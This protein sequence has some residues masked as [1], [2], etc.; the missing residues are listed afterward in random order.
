VAEA[1]SIG[2]RLPLGN[3]KG[4][5]W[6]AVGNAVHAFLAADVGGIAAGDRL[7][8]ARR[9]LAGS[10]LEA[11]LAPDALVRAGDQLRGWADS[12]WPEAIWRREVPVTAAVSTPH[13]ARRVQGIIDLLLETSDG[14]VIVDH[15]SFPGAASLWASKAVEFAPQLAVYAHVLQA[16]GKRVRGLFVHF[17]IGAG[18]ARLQQ[19]S[20]SA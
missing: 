10:D 16:A 5:S 20:S 7:E 11:V 2:K 3:T 13:G 8:L 17:T 14:V 9:L 1:R 12:H 15:K 4:V 19:N 6:D 18:I